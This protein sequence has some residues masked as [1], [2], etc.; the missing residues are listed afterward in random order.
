MSAV[1]GRPEEGGDVRRLAYVIHEAVCTAYKHEGRNSLCERAAVAVFASEYFTAAVEDAARDAGAE[2]TAAVLALAYEAVAAVGGSHSHW[3]EGGAG[4]V[5]R[6]CETANERQA[7]LRARL[8][9]LRESAATPREAEDRCGAQ[10]GGGRC[11]MPAGHDG[12]HGQV[13]LR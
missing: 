8:D 3:R 7:E 9:V 5:C 2:V 12:G 10:V 11:V 6:T 1:D 13:G 4:G